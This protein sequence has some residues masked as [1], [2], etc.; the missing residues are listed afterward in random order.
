V[1]TSHV[2]GV[3][4]CGPDGAVRWVDEENGFLVDS[5]W[6]FSMN[7]GWPNEEWPIIREDAHT[8]FWGFLDG[9]YSPDGPY[10]YP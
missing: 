5:P 9:E 10:T 8:K 6:S 1:A 7:E 4:V 2:D 3:N